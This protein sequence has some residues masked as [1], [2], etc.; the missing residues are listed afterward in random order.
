M[1]RRLEFLGINFSAKWRSGI[2][3]ENL[4][5]LSSEIDDLYTTNIQQMMFVIF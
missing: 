3:C 4:K 5:K 1:Q 2:E